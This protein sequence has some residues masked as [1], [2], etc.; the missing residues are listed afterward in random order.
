[1]WGS[2]LFQVFN[3]MAVACYSSTAGTRTTEYGHNVIIYYVVAYLGTGS[4]AIYIY[5]GVP[6][7]LEYTYL[8]LE[9]TRVYVPVHVYYT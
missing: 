2:M 4:I 1:M 8:V 3:S 5:I 7:V 6:I 9:C